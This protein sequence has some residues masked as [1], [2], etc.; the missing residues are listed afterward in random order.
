MITLLSVASAPHPV[1]STPL[2]HRIIL[3]TFRWL[4]GAEATG[5][6]FSDL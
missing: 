4:S 2:S 3:D 1:A 6:N 5:T